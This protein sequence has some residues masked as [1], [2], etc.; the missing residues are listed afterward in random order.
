MMIL[1]WLFYC[2]LFC[3]KQYNLSI[4]DMEQPL[5]INKPKRKQMS[6]G[7]KSKVLWNLDSLLHGAQIST[8]NT[9]FTV[10]KGGS[11]NPSFLTFFESL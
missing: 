3:R 9:V 2:M 6:R 4:S 5:L 1:G 10:L 11:V 7:V 8:F